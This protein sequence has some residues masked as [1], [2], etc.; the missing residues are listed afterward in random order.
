MNLRI[1]RGERV[2]TLTFLYTVLEKVAPNIVAA[3]KPTPNPRY[4][5]PVMSA[6]KP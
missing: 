1:E 5:R 2:R 4:V 3:K 6:E